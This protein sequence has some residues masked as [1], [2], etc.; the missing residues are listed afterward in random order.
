MMGGVGHKMISSRFRGGEAT[1]VMGGVELDL[2][3]ARAAGDTVVLNVLAWWG[4]IDIFVPKDWKVASEV[5]PI[6]AGYEDL[7]KVEPD[8]RTHLIVKGLVVMGGVEVKN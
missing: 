3:G 8:A 6:M 5:I 1:A 7:T 4:G 2:R